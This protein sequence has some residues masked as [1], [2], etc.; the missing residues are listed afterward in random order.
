M[1]R[2]ECMMMFKILS[3]SMNLLFFVIPAA[4][5][6]FYCFHPTD[7]KEIKYSNVHNKSI[8]QLPTIRFIQGF[9]GS[10][11]ATQYAAFIYLKEKMGVSVDWYPQ[12]EGNIIDPEILFNFEFEEKDTDPAFYWNWIE[13][14][15]YD[16]VFEQWPGS[17]F[18]SSKYYA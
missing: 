15:K 12:Q 13:K 18:Q 7:R 11:W 14:D 9:W 8:D 5:N 10:Q 16:V 17:E 4:S 1:S 6:Q 3:V 2:W